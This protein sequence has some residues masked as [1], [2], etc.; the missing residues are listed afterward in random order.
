VREKRSKLGEPCPKVRFSQDRMQI[1]LFPS[2]ISLVRGNSVKGGRV[3]AAFHQT[4]I[5]GFQSRIM[6]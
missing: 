5:G 2:R 1:E 4:C 3:G 6:C